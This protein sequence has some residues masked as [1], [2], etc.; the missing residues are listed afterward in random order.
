MPT[1]ME[2]RPVIW[3]ISDGKAGHENQS[4][5]LAEA[6]VDRVGGVVRVIG[7]EGSGVGLRARAPRVD[8]LGAPDVAI[9]A[10]SRTHAT[11]RACAREHGARTVVLMR[12]TFGR[13]ALV[14]AP[15]HDGM[16]ERDGVVTTRG[17]LNTV[18][19]SE[20]KND[21]RG[22]IL[23]GGPSKHHG[24]NDA[25][26]AQQIA[27]IVRTDA[28]VRWT[29]T[30]SRRTPEGFLSTLERATNPENLDVFHVEHT[31][32][33]WLLER[34]A[35]SARVWV[36]EDSVSMV[37]EALTSGARVGLLRVP[38]KGASRVI[39]GVDALASEGFV[40]RFDDWARDRT[41][42]APPEQLDEASRVARLVI[43]RFRLGA[44]EAGGDGGAS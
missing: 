32:R 10:G 26:V 30:T 4:R 22:L 17:A 6:I 25:D 29:L 21:S 15:R 24:W 37:Y 18:R 42:P 1:R 20:R 33:E 9:G 34:Y 31:S 14:V 27:E 16:R 44:G 38:R 28:D 2:Q 3:I 35:E 40:R 41:L 19:P 36:S 12:P 11:L 39:R 23:V 8:A 5:G 43:D 7:V 13:Y